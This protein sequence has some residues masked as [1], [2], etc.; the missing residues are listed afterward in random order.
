MS[1]TDYHPE[2]WNPA[3]TVSHILTG[4]V[5]FWYE[6][7]YTAGAIYYSGQPHEIKSKKKEQRVKAAFESRKNIL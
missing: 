3:W 1:M 2:S 7:I 6:D 4:L 5:S